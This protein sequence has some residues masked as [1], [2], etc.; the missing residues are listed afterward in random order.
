MS[1]DEARAPR[2]L[3]FAGPNGSGK[4][5]VT[6]KIHPVGLYVNADDIK[7]MLSCSDLEAAQKA[8]D[9]RFRLLDSR[10]DFTFETVLSSQKKIEFVA[11]AR[12]AGYQIQIIFVLTKSSAINVERVRNR[13]KNG[14]HPVPEDKIVSRFKRSLGNIPALTRLAHRMLVFDNTGECPVLLCEANGE[15]VTIVES[16]NWSKREI[17]DLLTGAN[18]PE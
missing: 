3:I 10:K 17:L 11:E 12:A 1:F 8:D 9:I 7:K 18:C 13:V 4:S 16:E 5:T 14:G 15:A 6:K 2:L